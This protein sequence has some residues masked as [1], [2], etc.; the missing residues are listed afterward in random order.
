MKKILTFLFLIAFVIGIAGTA[1]AVP[2]YASD[3]ID[4]ADRT[5]FVSF[6]SLPYPPKQP[7]LFIEDGVKIEQINGDGV[8][9]W[10][11]YTTWGAEGSGAWY[12]SGGDHGYTRITMVDSS[13]FYDVGFLRGS[14]A[15][16]HPWLAYILKNDGAVVDSGILSHTWAAQYL[17]FGGGGFDEILVRDGSNAG[18][19]VMDGTLNALAIDSIELYTSAPVPEPS[20][21]LLLLSGLLGIAGI[22]KKY[23]GQKKG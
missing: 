8:D 7:P 3:F 21:C 6:N 2:I 19:T 16:N 23:R 10:P 4:N 15:S 12:P 20:T 9:I 14:G 1:Q 13:D 11:R 18:I 22:K 5:N 17:G